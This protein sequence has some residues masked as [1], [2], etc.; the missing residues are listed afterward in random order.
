MPGTTHA[1][2]N[3]AR[4]LIRSLSRSDM[5]DPR[6]R[7][8]GVSGLGTDLVGR[9]GAAGGL[10]RRPGRRPQEALDLVRDGPGGIVELAPRVVAAG[11]QVG[12]EDARDGAVREARPRVA[13]RD[14]DVVDVVGVRPDE[15][16]PI[17]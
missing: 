15:G 11:D 1:A 6:A 2:A 17:Q 16:E 3:R 5:A 13:R 9:G 4:A 12:E 8:A 10:E 14:V 7:R